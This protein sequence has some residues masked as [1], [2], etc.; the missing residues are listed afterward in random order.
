KLPRCYGNMLVGWIHKPISDIHK[1][2]SFAGGL[3]YATGSRPN[4]IR[5]T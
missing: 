4:S 5:N 2:H 1:Q 3:I